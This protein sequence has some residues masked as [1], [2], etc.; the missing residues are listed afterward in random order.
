MP[1]PLILNLPLLPH[2]GGAVD[3][4][5]WIAAVEAPNCRQPLQQ[6]PFIAGAVA[7]GLAGIGRRNVG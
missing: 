1:L 4:P 7:T 2:P 5:S 6:L 3:R